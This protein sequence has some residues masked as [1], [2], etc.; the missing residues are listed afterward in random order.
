MLG[1]ILDH[2]TYGMPAD[3][4]VPHE[5]GL[6]DPRNQNPEESSSST[7]PNIVDRCSPNLCLQREEKMCLKSRIFM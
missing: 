7:V 2:D 6:L 3:F 5:A 4:D 1:E